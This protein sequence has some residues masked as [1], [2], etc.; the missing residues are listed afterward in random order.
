M[1]AVSNKYKEYI[2]NK[3]VE[4][5]WYG[6]IVF[7]DGTTVTFDN[8]NVDQN[9]SRLTRQLVK[10]E[11]LEVGGV[12]SGELILG[13]RDSA[14]WNI[15]DRSYDYEDAEVTLYFRLNFPDNTSESVLCGKFLVN[16]AERTYHTV[17][18]TAYDA[19][20]KLNE[21]LDHV[22]SG[23]FSPYDAISA[24]CSSAG[25]TFAMT[26][27]QVEALPNGRIST[28]K[29]ASY[30]KGVTY[31]KILG[32]ICTILGVNAVCDR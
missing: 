12:F 9:K 14:A 5:V 3:T 2:A 30:K 6:Q 16:K 27:A 13:L 1:W 24:V 25:V 22:Y 17:T 28:L 7:D 11:N 20:N 18:L 21:K 19:I 15:S 23:L 32:D 4:Y 31:K 29:M 10:G 26:R 8:E